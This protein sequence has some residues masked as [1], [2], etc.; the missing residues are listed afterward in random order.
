MNILM[1]SG[2][3]N[4]STAM[5]RAFGA[6]GDCA[7][8]DEPFY[9]P[10]L[11]ATGIEHPMRDDI[12]QHHDTNADAVSA[13]CAASA[14]DG[15]PHFYQKHMTHHMLGGF[16][17]SFMDNAQNVFLIREP[18]R[19]LASYVEKREEVTLPEIGF[20]A[21]AELFDRVAQKTGAAPVVVDAGDITKKPEAALKALCGALG[22]SWT[23]NM[24]HWQPGI[25][26]TDGVW[27]AHWYNAVAKSTGFTPTVE[28]PLPQL[29]DHLQKIADAA[30]PYYVLLAGSAA[31]TRI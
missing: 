24:L 9:A 18:E 25:H 20:V 7:V 27:A 13:A 26:K 23:Q 4:L 12:L 8:W 5:M 10:Y 2:P 11:A 28:K 1:W 16:D 17:L 14:R 31:R 21:Q 22:I 3:R 30:R 29:P 19:V 15:S 6:R